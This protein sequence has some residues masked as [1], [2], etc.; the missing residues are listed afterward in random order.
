LYL[1]ITAAVITAIWL[2]LVLMGKRGFVH[3]L[4]LNVLGI[5]AVDLMNVFRTKLTIQSNSERQIR[6]PMPDQSSK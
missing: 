5:V 3:I 2:T 1:R 6:H 4:I